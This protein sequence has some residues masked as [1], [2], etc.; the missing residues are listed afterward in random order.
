MSLFHLHTLM[1]AG[2]VIVDLAGEAGGNCELTVPGEKVVHNGVTIL[3]YT[4]LPSRL[5]TQSSTLYSNNITKVSIPPDR[6]YEDDPLLYPINP[7][8]SYIL[9][10]HL[11]HLLF[12]LSSLP[13]HA[14]DAYAAGPESRTN[15]RLPV[16]S[17]S[18]CP[19]DDLR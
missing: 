16:S 11:F 19:A 2:S 15:C 6:A 18:P 3:G 7:F 1:K 8:Y 14:S 12:L 17:A 5:P 10:A 9:S 13:F 4:D